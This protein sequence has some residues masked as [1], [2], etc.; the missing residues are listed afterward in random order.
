MPVVAVLV[1][2]QAAEFS[3]DR[4]VKGARRR[5]TAALKGASTAQ[6][7]ELLYQH[8]IN[9]NE[10]PAWQRR[11]ISLHWED[12]SKT[13]CDPRTG[14]ETA[15]IRRRLKVNDQLPIKMSTARWSRTCSQ[16]EG[17]PDPETLPK[18]PPHSPAAKRKAV[19]SA[20]A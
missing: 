17:K 6:Q 8:G 20:P 12:Y 16:A 19:P 10:T 3:Q 1:G 18:M 9:F 15:A 7:N 11:G 13:G 5:A 14:A 4:A 2:L